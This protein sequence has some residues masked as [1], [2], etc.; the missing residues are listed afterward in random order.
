MVQ[1]LGYTIEGAVAASGIG[2]TKLYDAIRAGQLRARKCGRRTIILDDDLR[3]FLAALP[4]SLGED[5]PA[6]NDRPVAPERPGRAAANRVARADAPH[7]AAQSA[8][9]P[10]SE[11]REDFLLAGELRRLET[12]KAAE[13]ESSTALP[14][15]GRAP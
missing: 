7:H 3:A 14:R 12:I 5:E 9:G 2:R 13:R 11:R 15:T 10:S 6:Q 1:P 4:E 8:P